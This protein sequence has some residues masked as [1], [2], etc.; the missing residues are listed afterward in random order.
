MDATPLSLQN[1]LAP[2]MK[3]QEG[4]SVS[5]RGHTGMMR[6]FCKRKPSSTGI[7]IRK[8]SATCRSPEKGP[9]I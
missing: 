5:P 2:W 9:P 4:S 8:S 3:V 6:S 1:H 7:E